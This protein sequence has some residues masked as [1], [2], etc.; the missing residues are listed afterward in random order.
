MERFTSIPSHRQKVIEKLNNIII[1]WLMTNIL[2]N[3]LS[4]SWRLDTIAD[5]EMPGKE[6]EI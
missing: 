1:A 6:F 2:L 3:I 4:N 5:L